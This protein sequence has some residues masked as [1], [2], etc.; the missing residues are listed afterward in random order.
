MS[1]LFLRK[2]IIAFSALLGL[3]GTLAIVFGIS[4]HYNSKLDQGKTTNKG[5]ADIAL[6]LSTKNN[7]FFAAVEE[8]VREKAKELNLSVE[9]YDSINKVSTEDDN[10]ARII[11]KKHPIVIFNDVNEDSGIAAV[12]KF[13][14][15]KIPVIALDHILFGPKVKE[16]GIE[17]V[18]NIASDN[19]Q[20]G[21]IIAQFL[22]QKIKLPQD[23]LTYI[24]YGIPGTESG[25]SRTKGFNIPVKDLDGNDINYNVYGYTLI[26]EAEKYGKKYYSDQADDNRSLAH[27]KTNAR[28]G[29]FFSANTVDKR[30]NLI[31]GTN[32][33]AAI[34]AISAILKQNIKDVD[35]KGIL[36][37]N[38]IY[39]EATKN[40]VWVTGIDY[41]KD[42]IDAIVNQKT[43]TATVEQETN[44]LGAIATLIAKKVLENQFDNS[45]LQQY[46]EVFPQ[47][48]NVPTSDNQTMTKGFYFQVATKIF[49]AG[50]DGKGEKL[51][52]DANGKLVRTQ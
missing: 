11:A 36:A 17:V 31:F 3:G 32:D 37:G 21:K 25:M 29:Q 6:L 22:A 12:R 20:A 35:G 7:P 51:T 30:P 46:K 49:W 4:S 44:A 19:V 2:L 18:A 13:N 27:D 43:M 42:A 15:A 14:R 28:I 16:A 10:V 1:K 38:Q 39:S 48:T 26:G 40:K 34:G 47:I 50:E 33:E 5:A 9:T 8:G 52:A 45:T 41:T 24:L 23:I